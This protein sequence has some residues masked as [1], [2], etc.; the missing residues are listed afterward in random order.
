MI[1]RISKR[2]YTV[3]YTRLKVL[4]FG[5]DKFSVSS[6]ELL[7]REF[8][9]KGPVEKLA[10][11]TNTK[12]SRTPNPVKKF[13]EKFKVEI[14]PWPVNEEAFRGHYDIGVVVSFGHL[15][16]SSLIETFPLGMINVHG[17]LLPR[18]RGAAPIIHALKTGD[19]S[20]GVTIMRIRPKVFDIGEILAQRQIPIE[21]DTLMP[22]LHDNLARIGGQLL[23]DCLH[24]LQDVLE[25]AKPQPSE[26]VTRAPKVDKTPEMIKWNEM[27]STEIYRHFCAYF[28]FKFLQT[29]WHEI[30]VKVLLVSVREITS[31]GQ[32]TSLRDQPPGSFI[33]HK[34]ER[35]FI[36]KCAK[37]TYLNVLQVGLEGKKAMSALDFYNGFIRKRPKSADSSKF[38]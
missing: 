30:S 5:N 35:C 15:L 27:T 29:N 13:A 31:S 4:F 19:T 7:N 1:F 2:F 34:Q 32:L 3:D 28:S 16:S 14:Y 17:S 9:S 22:D 12:K 36:V 25:N 20:T 37:E 26:G 33:L 8:K 6:L 38:Q 23:V 21:P 24:N 11:V 18:W 10:V